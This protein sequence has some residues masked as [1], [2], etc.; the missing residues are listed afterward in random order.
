[1]LA[2]AGRESEP[3]VLV[4]ELDVEPGLGGQVEDER[5][6][7][8]QEG[9]PDRASGHHLDR[10]LA[11]DAAALGEQHALAEGEHLRG[12]ADVDCEL[13]PKALAVRTDVPDDL[14]ELV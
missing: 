5:S 4:R 13:E 9:R 3:D 6:A 12:E 2:P 8:V 7:A 14:T 10:Q 11:R 1:V